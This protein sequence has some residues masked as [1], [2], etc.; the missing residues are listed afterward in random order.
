MEKRYLLLLMDQLRKKLILLCLCHDVNL[1]SK[2]EPPAEISES[3]R[4]AYLL[5][6][7]RILRIALILTNERKFFLAI[8]FITPIP[9]IL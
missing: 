8:A 7:I 4:A 5:F 2:N 9:C 6:L 3:F 1:H